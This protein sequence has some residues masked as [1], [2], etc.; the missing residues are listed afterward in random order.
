MH[1]VATRGAIGMISFAK[2]R[3]F[4]EFFKKYNDAYPK[5][6]SPKDKITGY[7]AKNDA[8]L[9]RENS[10]RSFV[11]QNKELGLYFLRCIDT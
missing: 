5:L 1:R 2:W 4:V 11:L 9:Q 3:N 10:F 7:R 6:T 8:E